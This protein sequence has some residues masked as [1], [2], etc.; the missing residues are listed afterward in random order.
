MPAIP[1][2]CVMTFAKKILCRLRD[3]L[4]QFGDFLA[5]SLYRSHPRH[6]MGGATDW[7][8]LVA[9]LGS[10]SQGFRTRPSRLHRSRDRGCDPRRVIWTYG[11]RGVL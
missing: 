8:R 10:T 11:A 5:V 3:G 1:T 9:L 6:G 4:E 2:A 7:P